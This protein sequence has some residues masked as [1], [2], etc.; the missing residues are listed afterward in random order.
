MNAIPGF[1]RLSLGNPHQKERQ[2]AEK[3][4]SLD[5]LVLAM[6]ERSKLKG[7]LQ[8]PES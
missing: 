5:S 7:G 2:V 4:M 6:I 3:Y 1:S 8:R